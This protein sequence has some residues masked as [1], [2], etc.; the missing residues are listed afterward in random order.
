[1]RKVDHTARFLRVFWLPPSSSAFCFSENL[2]VWDATPRLQDNLGIS[3]MLQG[4]L[5]GNLGLRRGS[6]MES[7]ISAYAFRIQLCL[8]D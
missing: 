6:G 7:G 3:E 5:S 8:Q 4:P 1:M 2:A